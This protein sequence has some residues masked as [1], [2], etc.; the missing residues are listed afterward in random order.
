MDPST[1]NYGCH[2]DMCHQRDKGSGIGVSFYVAQ[3]RRAAKVGQGRGHGD[4]GFI[5][6]TLSLI[7]CR[8]MSPLLF[9]LFQISPSPHLLNFSVA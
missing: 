7:Y 9:P 4:I 3:S 1:E 8:A 5:A 2:G 6:G